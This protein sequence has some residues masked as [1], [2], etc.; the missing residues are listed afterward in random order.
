[1][2]HAFSTVHAGNVRVACV[3]MCV[4]ART[5]V[6]RCA[7]EC[8]CTHNV[9]AHIT[10]TH[11]CTYLPGAAAGHQKVAD[12]LLVGVDR[13]LKRRLLPCALKTE[14]KTSSRAVLASRRERGASQGRAAHGDGAQKGRHNQQGTEIT[15]EGGG[16]SVTLFIVGVQRADYFRARRLQKNHPLMTRDACWGACAL[17]CFSSTR[18]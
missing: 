3:C 7:R 2:Q 6:S 9:S 18:A 1:M 14:R 17:A 11:E 4:C 13:V 15:A 16:R 5:R 10:F 8:E 12:L